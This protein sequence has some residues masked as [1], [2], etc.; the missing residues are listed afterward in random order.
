MQVAVT[1]S[2]SVRDKVS[3]WRNAVKQALR[4]LS[5]DLLGSSKAQLILKGGRLR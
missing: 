2:K 4:L 3:A 1:S 5:Q